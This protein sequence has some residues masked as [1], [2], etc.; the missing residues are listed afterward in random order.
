MEKYN[1]T[2]KK[3]KKMGINL[4]K[5]IKGENLSNYYEYWGWTRILLIDIMRLIK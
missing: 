3:T 2:K 1:K 5:K 4:F